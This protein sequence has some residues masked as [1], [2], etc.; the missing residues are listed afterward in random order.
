MHR[1]ILTFLFSLVVFVAGAAAQNLIV[2][3]FYHAE[4]DFT[5]NRGSTCILDQNDEPCALIKV[6]TSQ[7]GQGVTQNKQEAK[8]WIQKA[9]ERGDQDAKDFLKSNSF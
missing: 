1:R 9:A 5:A 8:R 4:R 6:R 7:R 2:K 3:N